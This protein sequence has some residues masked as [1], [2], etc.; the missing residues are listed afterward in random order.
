MRYKLR[1]LVSFGD[2]YIFST[3]MTKRTQRNTGNYVAG[4]C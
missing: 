3:K 4:S 1:Y 2:V